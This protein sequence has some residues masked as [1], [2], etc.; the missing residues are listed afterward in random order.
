MLPS[1]PYP[2]TSSFQKRSSIASERP[3]LH[4][5]G[6]SSLNNFNNNSNISLTN[7]NFNYSLKYPY[8]QNTGG[9]RN[10]NN[11]NY[12]DSNNLYST[13][14]QNALLNNDL[15]NNNNTS[16][17][18]DL[19]HTSFYESNYPLYGLD[20]TFSD[21]RQLS[22]IALS[23]Y[24][25]DKKNSLKILYG[26]PFDTTHDNTNNNHNSTRN[27]DYD[28]DDENNNNNNNNND[29]NNDDNSDNNDNSNNN[30]NQSIEDDIEN[31]NFIKKF[32]YTVKYPITK[33]QWDPSIAI[34]SYSLT[35]LLATTSECLRIY[36]LDDENLKLI[37]KSALTSSKIS[38]L[39]QL[40]PMTSLDWNKFD[41]THLITCSIDTTCTAW[42]LVKETFVAKTQL[43]AHDSEVYD[44]KYI[45]KDINL[46]TSCSSDGS[47]RLFDLRNLEQSTIIYENINNNKTSLSPTC[48]S[49]SS[50]STFSPSSTIST[51]LLRLSTSNY[52]PNQIAVLQEYSNKI[53]I[54]DLRNVGLPILTLDNHSSSINSIAWHP[55]KNQLIS[56]SDDCQIFIYDFNS[57]NLNN[58][59]ILPNYKFQTEN[60]I[61]NICWN[62]I[63]DWVGINNGKQFQAVKTV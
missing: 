57:Q 13:L 2:N 36:Q 14:N 12:H 48:L 34:S 15:G 23:T 22:K 42:N 24:H 18:S 35:D 49:S 1:Y 19:A 4:K 51:K 55:S 3:H 5:Y 54:L 61:N 58:D 29:N 46:F 41:P 62:H 59:S 32:D 47:V 39:N 26:Y 10:N 52:N 53:L 50:V 28:Y 33:L 6:M 63:G 9:S 43:I 60:E 45:S 40:P 30:N 8:Q 38:N 21:N 20:W 37:E 7:S 27:N 44:V 25:E 11:N 31:W 17:L 16:E 56:G